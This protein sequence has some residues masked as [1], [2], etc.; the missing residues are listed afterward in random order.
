MLISGAF[1]RGLLIGTVIGVVL[2]LL[3]A[4]RRGAETK[5]AIRAHLAN[6]RGEAASARAAAEQEV[7]QRYEAIVAS[8]PTG[9]QA[10]DGT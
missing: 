9:E 8:S 1:W 7:L 5:E 10:G 3:L 6:A 4:P 2:G